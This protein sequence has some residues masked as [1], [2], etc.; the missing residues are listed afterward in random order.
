M[1][2]DNASDTAY[3]AYGLTARE[4]QLIRSVL[5]GHEKVERALI[6]GSRGLGTH[7]EGSDVD[8]ALVGAALSDQDRLSIM[9]ALDD[10]DLLLDYDVLLWPP[11]DDALRAV[12]RQTGQVFYDRGMHG[13]EARLAS[14]GKNR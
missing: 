14:E 11:S 6:F 7:R 8:L 2:P 13:K 10:L 9:A 1:T 12:I 4:I 5:A 3:V